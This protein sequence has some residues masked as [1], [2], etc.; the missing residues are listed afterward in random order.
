[1]LYGWGGTSGHWNQSLGQG[2][3]ESSPDYA[4]GAK[5]YYKVH[6]GQNCAAAYSDCGDDN[7][8]T[9]NGADLAN[10]ELGTCGGIR[11]VVV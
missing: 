3:V 7:N 9:Q 5:P 11:M 10:G 1:M 6:Y 8:V 2:L 4:D